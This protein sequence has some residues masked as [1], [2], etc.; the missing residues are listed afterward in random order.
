L[1]STPEYHMMITAIGIPSLRTGQL[2]LFIRTKQFNDYS[3]VVFRRL[4]N[5]LRIS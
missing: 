5:S 1:Y 3:R 2:R 4:A